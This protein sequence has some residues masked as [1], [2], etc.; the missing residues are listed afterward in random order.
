[1]HL[2]TDDGSDGPKTKVSLI[3]FD[4]YIIIQSSCF[5]ALGLQYLKYFLQS[6]NESSIIPV[7]TSLLGIPVEVREIELIHTRIQDS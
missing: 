5:I 4:Y 7:S 1:M 6:E 2:E 3:G